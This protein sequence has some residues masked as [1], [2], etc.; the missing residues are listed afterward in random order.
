MRVGCCE[1]KSLVIRSCNA[2]NGGG[3]I[4][5]CRSELR[6][7]VITL[8]R[9]VGL[10]TRSLECVRCAR[11]GAWK[12]QI[13]VAV[14][15]AHCCASRRRTVVKPSA[16]CDAAAG[17]TAKE[18]KKRWCSKCAKRYPEV[19]RIT[20][21]ARSNT[22][23]V[24]DCH[25]RQISSLLNTLER[26]TAHR[27]AVV[28]VAVVTQ[29]VKSR[30]QKEQSQREDRCAVFQWARS[31]CTCGSPGNVCTCGGVRCAYWIV[32]E[33][34]NLKNVR[35]V[36]HESLSPMTVRGN[37]E[38]CYHLILLARRGRTVPGSTS[39]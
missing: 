17:P 13:V 20:C 30:T 19:C 14:P 34:P 5:S 15:D 16:V 2:S 3:R 27:C 35:A 7:G 9:T 26:S 4:I 24:L 31:R 25:M 22:G 1:V 32:A 28:A 36:A 12:L 23:S 29:A 33:C 37:S 10:P 11:V 21:D 6:F 38:C 8:C 18:N 39:A